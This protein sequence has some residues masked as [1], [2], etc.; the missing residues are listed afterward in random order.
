MNMTGNSILITGGTSGIGFELARQLCQNNTVIITGRDRRKLELSKAKLS[1]AHVMQSDVSDPDAISALYEK[2]TQ[3]FPALN[4]LINNAGIMRK[5]NLQAGAGD[6]RDITRE[7]ETNLNGPIRIVKQFLPHLQK[8]RRAAIV[9]VS[10]GLAF[11]PFPISPIYSATK[12]GL[13]AFTQALR[14]QL[15]KTNIKVFEL[16]PPGTETPLLRGDFDETDLGGVTGMDVTKLATL[17]IKGMKR[18]VLEIRPGLSNVLKL[19]SRISP[20]LALTMLA[21][22]NAASLDR[23]QAQLEAQ[24]QQVYTNGVT[25]QSER[26][27]FQ[28][29]I[30]ESES[31]NR[32]I[33]DQ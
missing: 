27:A 1:T 19:L 2:V 18:D 21:K 12:A 20:A 33:T 26:L 28:K 29:P 14:V 25:E 15:R 16:A 7:I 24:K 17:A 6:L 4:I 11:V 30:F 32:A 5:I 23:M 13:H 10:S 9:N 3:N 31:R 22:S 8:Q